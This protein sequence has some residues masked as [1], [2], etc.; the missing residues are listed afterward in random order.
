LTRDLIRGG[1]LLK[2]KVL[3]HVIMGQPFGA[4]GKDYQS[5]RELGFFFA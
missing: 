5:I 1:Q 2:I 4:V 3:D